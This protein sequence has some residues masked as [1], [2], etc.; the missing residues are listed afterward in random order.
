MRALPVWKSRVEVQTLCYCHSKPHRISICR[1]KLLELKLVGSSG[2]SCIDEYE[3]TTTF[4]TLLAVQSAI[5]YT[6]L[7]VSQVLVSTY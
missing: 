6:M 1:A 2:V 4:N 3:S 7:D 5:L